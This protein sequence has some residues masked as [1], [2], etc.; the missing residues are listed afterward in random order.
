MA[1]V[2]ILEPP[3]ADAQ[4]IEFHCTDGD[5]NKWPV[6]TSEHDGDGNINF[7]RPVHI[8]EKSAVDWRRKIGRQMA[9]QLNRPGMVPF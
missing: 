7:Y 5:R 3:P 9:E 1:R 4:W 8:D 6:F 2:F